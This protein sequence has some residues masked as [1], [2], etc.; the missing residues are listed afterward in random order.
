MLNFGHSSRE[1]QL[2]MSVALFC[3]S[4]GKRFKWFA[5]RIVILLRWKCFSQYHLVDMDAGKEL[6]ESFW[7]WFSQIIKRRLPIHGTP[8]IG[9]TKVPR[10]GFLWT[11]IFCKPSFYMLVFLR[12]STWL[13]KKFQEIESAKVTKITLRIYKKGSR[14]KQESHQGKWSRLTHPKINHSLSGAFEERP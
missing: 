7:Q 10:S 13:L 14:L 1:I 9:M 4:E 11:N 3:R 2:S 8:K 5:D 12:I 6:F